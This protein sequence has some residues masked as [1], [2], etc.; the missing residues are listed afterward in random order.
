MAA[1]VAIAADLFVEMSTPTLRIPNS[2]EAIRGSL[3]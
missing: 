2:A 3:R 1:E